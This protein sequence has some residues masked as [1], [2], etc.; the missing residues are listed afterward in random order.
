MSAM[1]TNLHDEKFKRDSSVDGWQLSRRY[2]YQNYNTASSGLGLSLI[3][4]EKKI[5]K[6]AHEKALIAIVANH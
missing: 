1:L 2:K 3:V 4:V 5:I 6:F